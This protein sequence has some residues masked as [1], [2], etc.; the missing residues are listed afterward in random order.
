M[1]EDVAQNVDFEK[2][3][4]N[5]EEFDK[6]NQMFAHMMKDMDKADPTTSNPFL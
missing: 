4:F 3:G 1:F 2:M 5:K 6:A